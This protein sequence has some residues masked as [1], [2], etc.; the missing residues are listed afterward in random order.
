MYVDVSYTIEKVLYINEDENFIKFVYNL[1]KSWY[2][3]FLTFQNLK[4][5]QDNFIFFDE[6]DIM[7]K[8]WLENIN[9]ENR[10][11]C[12]QTE[13]TE[14]LVVEPND[15]F[16]LEKSPLTDLKNGYLFKGSENKI[17]QDWDWT[18]EYICQFDYYWYPFDTQNCPMIINVS[19]NK[20][21]VRPEKIVY[22]GSMDVGRYYFHSINYCQ[23]SKDGRTGS[24]FIDFTIRRPVL[25]N[26][27]TLFF[28]TG[29]LVLIS[30][31]STAFSKTF[32]DMVIEVNTTL[33]L[34]LTTL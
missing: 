34:V 30:Q 32:R 23:R 8:P 7:W 33:L 17:S 2:N 22:N 14:L 18:C 19:S 12:K 16:N 21:Q 26:M 28:P 20:Y 5:G 1:K 6:K 9:M 3:S 15:K 4:Q 25:N 13:K 24:L 31:M 10:N 27:I 29:M 11:K